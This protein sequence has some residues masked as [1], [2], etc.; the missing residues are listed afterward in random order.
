MLLA[1]CADAG[2]L[3]G[4]FVFMLIAGL[5][6]GLVLVGLCVLASMGV[7]KIVD[8]L[9]KRPETVSLFPHNVP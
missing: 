3:I 9:R 4:F 1:M 6:V 5:V 8:A 7:A 2:M